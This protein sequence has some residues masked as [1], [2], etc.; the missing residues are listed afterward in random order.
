MAQGLY[1][2]VTAG[3]SPEHI[4]FITAQHKFGKNI[5]IGGLSALFYHGLIDQ[6]PQQVWV[7]VPPTIRTT[8]RRYRLI[9][10]K[11][12]LDIGIEQHD[13]FRICDIDRAVVEAFRFS[14]KMGL[15]NAVTA[16]I[17]AIKEKKTT[18]PKIMAMARAMGYESAIL[19]HGET[20]TGIMENT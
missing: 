8:D 9:R 14:A 10:T 17:R 6:P 13:L 3:L 15:Q 12:P 2:D 11:G 19:K 16:A 20:L 18:F 5:V 7:I 4:D 1:L